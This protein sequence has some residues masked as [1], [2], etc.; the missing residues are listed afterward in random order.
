MV[1]RRVT[2]WADPV[3]NKKI[4]DIQKSIMMNKGQKI[5]ATEITKRIVKSAH[6]QEVEKHIVD[7][8]YLSFNIGIKFDKRKK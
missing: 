3:F 2:L 1:Q 5:S 6:F 4:K 7:P 8:D